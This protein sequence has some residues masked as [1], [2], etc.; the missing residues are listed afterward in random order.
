[1]FETA[2]VL[3][4]IRSLHNVGSIFRTA[5]AAGVSK[6]YLCGI[7]PEPFDRLGRPRSDLAKVALGAEE[8]MP[9]EHCA[10]AARC[11]DKLKNSGWKIF[12]VEQSDKSVPYS[13]AKRGL[14]RGSKVALVMGD[15]VRGLPPSIL[16]RADKILEIPMRGAMIRQAHHPRHS[17]RGKESLNVSVAF[18]I[19]VFGLIG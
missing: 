17:H 13:E 15:E 16:A 9:W 11:L 12:A 10:S 6:V 5:D 18:G 14:K 19:A 7:T 2:V 8:W 3:H 4:N 1:M